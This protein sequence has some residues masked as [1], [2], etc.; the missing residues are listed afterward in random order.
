MK[1]WQ[2]QLTWRLGLWV[3][4][5]GLVSGTWS[6]LVPL[7]ECI[8]GGH[9]LASVPIIMLA[10]PLDL[11]P[12]VMSHRKVVSKRVGDPHTEAEGRR[13]YD[14]RQETGGNTQCWQEFS[15]WS[16]PPQMASKGRSGV[17]FHNSVPW[18]HL[19]I[20]AFLSY[21]TDLVPIHRDGRR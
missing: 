20:S 14:T 17:L 10:D 1:S 12:V 3:A 11:R 2:K 6:N 9:V 8:L 16:R 7:H 19:P 5:L 18:C 13:A 4:S 15:S 21:V